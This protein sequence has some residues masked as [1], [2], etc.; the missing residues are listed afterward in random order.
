MASFYPKRSRKSVTKKPKLR[1]K[2]TEKFSRFE[3]A[4]CDW[5]K[6]RFDNTPLAGSYHVSRAVKKQKQEVTVEQ[7]FIALLYRRHD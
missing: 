2:I 7:D 4:D 3:F 1:N 6:L 5:L